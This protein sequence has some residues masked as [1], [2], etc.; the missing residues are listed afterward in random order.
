[1]CVCVCILQKQN[2]FFPAKNIIFDK[3]TA[4]NVPKLV[5]Q[6]LGLRFRKKKFAVDN[7]FDIKM[8]I[9]LILTFD[10]DIYAFID[11]KDFGLFNCRFWC[12]VSGSYRRTQVSSL[13]TVFKWR[14]F[15]TIMLKGLKIYFF[16][17]FLTNKENT[18]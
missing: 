10:F 13:V 17:H 12:F 16:S 2:P 1:M 11:F 14:V 7:S 5:G 6:M 18:T 15:S 9:C 4:V 3:S 8:R